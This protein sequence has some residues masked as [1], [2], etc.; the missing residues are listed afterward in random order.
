MPGPFS[1]TDLYDAIDYGDQRMQQLRTLRTQAMADYG[2]R[3]WY[4]DDGK[5]RPLNLVKRGIKVL[6]A[7]LAARNPRFEVSTERLLFRG[8]ARK[9]QK[10][11]DIRAEQAGM[12]KFQRLCMMEACFGGKA[13]VR[14]GQRS[15]A[16]VVRVSADRYISR[17]QTYRQ[18]VSLDDWIPDPSARNENEMAFEAMRYRLPRKAAQQAVEDGIFGY[19]ATVEN[20]ETPP[21][22]DVATPEE[23]AA[24]IAGATAMGDGRTGERRDRGEDLT[25]GNL[26]DEQRFGL[27]DTVELLDVAIYLDADT[28]V[29][30][31]MLADRGTTPKY[32]RAEI[33]DGPSRGPFEHLEFDPVPD[34]PNGPSV[35]GDMREQ[36]D[37]ANT[38]L[39]KMVHQIE[40]TRRVLVYKKNRANDALKI[41]K[42]QDGGSIGIDGE[43]ADIKDVAMGGVSPELAPFAQMLVGFWNMQGSFDVLGGQA[44]GASRTA[45]ED[46]R[47]GQAANILIESL[48]D[49]A[50]DFQS[51][52][53]KHE[54]WYFWNDPF[55]SAPM[56]I[57]LDGAAE[58]EVTYDAE[59]RK[60]TFADYT[61]KIRPRSMQRVDANV[62]MARFNELLEL[63]L[64]A[65]EAEMATQGRVDAAAFVRIA[66]RR[67]EEDDLDE[68][69]RDPIL[70]AELQDLY[71]NVPT[72][73][74]RGQQPQQPGQP[75]G[76]PVQPMA[77]PPRAPAQ[78]GIAQQQSVMQSAYAPM[79]A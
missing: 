65:A 27:I 49:F 44:G 51:R 34:N 5:Q 47:L 54:A 15:S 41:S 55:I 36:A 50:D 70:M 32:L 78:G 26:T 72:P 14:V 66:G 67:M 60:G 58:V 20:A 30:V 28:C 24:L 18:L 77:L 6:V 48:A 10:Q 29:V 8:D 79:S 40:R 42:T 16:D 64:R 23:A 31:T 33:W 68:M 71:A 9:M 76:M 53:V 25:A 38:V 7:H 75:P 4:E 21:M 43:I 59:Q 1:I 57:R 62:S 13:V 61:F 45:T 11:L 3:Y 73:P 69:F 46:A 74:G 63:S 19:D 17:G 2:G 56:T 35:A 22:D 52:L 37:L 39:G 12:V